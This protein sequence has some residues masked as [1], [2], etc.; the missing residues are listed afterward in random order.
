[1]A[2][3]CDLTNKNCKPCEGGVPALTQDEAKN[4]L[5]QLDGWEL[6]D[7][8]ISKTFA[9]KNYYQVLAFVNAV[10]WM[11]HREDHHPDMSVGYSKC[12]VEYSTHAIGGLSENDFICAAKVDALFK[13]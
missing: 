3:V 5:K 2:T 10:A 1:M 7:N 4:L 13:L 6:G 12:R 11:T 9:F 8:T